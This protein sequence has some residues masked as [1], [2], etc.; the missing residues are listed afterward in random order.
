LSDRFINQID[1]KYKCSVV[2]LGNTNHVQK[3]INFGGFNKVLNN[4]G[5][6]LS[7]V[8]LKVRTKDFPF[9]LEFSKSVHR[10]K[11]KQ[12]ILE[13]HY[14]G[15][16]ERM[17]DYVTLL[18]ALRELRRSH[19][20]IYWF[21]RNWEF[22]ENVRTKKR[23]STCYTINMYLKSPTLTSQ[24]ES[25][26]TQSDSGFP[27]M[28]PIG[29]KRIPTETVLRYQ[30]IF[31][32]SILRHSFLCKQMLRLGNIVDGG[33]DVCH[34][35]RFRPKS[36][37]I[38]YSFGISYDFSFDEDMEKTYGC[39]VFSFDPSMNTGNYRHSEHI[40]FYQVG[41]GDKVSEIEVKGNKWK[42]KNL[43]TIMK[44]LGHTDRRIDVL[45]IDIEGSERQSLVEMMESGALKNVVQLCLEFHS[46]YDLGAMRILYDLGFR[47]F[48]A[49][50][51]PHAPMYTRNETYSY[52]MEVYFVNINIK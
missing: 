25:T 34:D 13:V 46:Y 18:N 31:A 29:A 42:I 28:A 45:K 26:L 12:I 49:H 16:Y 17:E 11:V 23:R 21:D 2:F 36:P 1:A 51:N 22:V 43:M 40:T 6:E 38:V 48:W 47:V 44:E 20:A 8:I 33:W 9:L 32:K 3:S 7:V 4:Y 30:E 19:Y 10:V 24:Q 27:E 14:D 35:F 39:D 41:L 5:R 50:Q 37:C 52:G 15:K